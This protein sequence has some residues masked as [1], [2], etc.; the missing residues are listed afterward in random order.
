LYAHSTCW[1][2]TGTLR[3][4]PIEERK[5]VLANL[6]RRQR[7]GISFN[8]HYTSDSD[9]AIIYEHACALGCE[10]IVSKR[11]GSPISGCAL[12]ALQQRQHFGLLRLTATGL[13][14]PLRD[15]DLL[16]FG[17]RPHGQA[18][19][20]SLP[21]AR[22]AGL[23]GLLWRA[24]VNSDGR[25][26]PFGNAQR[27]RPRLIVTAPHRHCGASR[28]F[29]DQSVPQQ[30]PDNLAG[31]AALEIRDED[32][33]RRPPAARQQTAVRVGYQ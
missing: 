18:F 29:F 32:K 9:G 2:S 23:R 7:D 13:G 19:W 11:L 33:W 25:K 26:A 6:L 24:T 1:N 5:R 12:R 27:P 8:E 28:D 15:P 16:S 22:W 10:G 31:C 30:L 20:V 17:E 14:R 3:R 4:S 21:A